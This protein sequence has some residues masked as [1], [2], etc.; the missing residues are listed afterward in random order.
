MMTA[1]EYQA[2]AQE[3]ERLAR[4]GDPDLRAMYVAMAVQW[5][6]FAEQLELIEVQSQKRFVVKNG[7]RELVEAMN[8]GDIT[9]AMALD[10]ARLPRDHQAKC[11][12]DEKLRH[13]FTRIMHADGDKLAS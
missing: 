11:L 8:K 1:D 6:L 2:K 13:F 4:D 9:I 12:I 7:C 3:C 5:R 10:L